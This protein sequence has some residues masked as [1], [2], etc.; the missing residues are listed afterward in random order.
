LLKAEAARMAAEIAM[1][2]AHIHA[3]FDGSV[4]ARY[5]DEG[6]QVG[7]GQ[8]II[9]L[10][11]TGKVEAHI[12]VPEVLLSRLEPDSTHQI[13]WAGNTY[14]ATLKA[15]LPE[16]D[17]ATRTLTAIFNLKSAEI[18]LGA[19][20]ELELESRITSTGYWLPLTALTESDRGLW[21]IFVIN[22]DSSVERRLVEIIH[23][24]ADAA[25]V[26]GTLNPGE[27]VVTT[28]VQRIVPGQKVEPV[29]RG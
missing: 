23:A 27:R 20:V 18:P 24:E 1:T 29:R 15:M 19:V 26:R 7:A 6:A 13:R 3:P 4:Q 2:E 25:Y 8:K 10:D 28:G 9:R 17:P 5:V 22:E 11:E 21:G 12:G 16:V 14:P